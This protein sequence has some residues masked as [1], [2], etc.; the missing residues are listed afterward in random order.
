VAALL[1]TEKRRLTSVVSW[2]LAGSLTPETATDSGVSPPLL[3]PG[4]RRPNLAWTLRKGNPDICLLQDAVPDNLLEF[5]KSDGVLRDFDKRYHFHRSTSGGCVIATLKERFRDPEAC[6]LTFEHGEAAAMASFNSSWDSW[7]LCVSVNIRADT[8]LH[9]DAL[10]DFAQQVAQHRHSFG[11]SAKLLCGVSVSG[12]APHSAEWDEELGGRAAV[13][14]VFNSLGASRD[15]LNTDTDEMARRPTW[16]PLCEGGSMP[17]RA[18]LLLMSSDLDCIK[19]QVAD[20]LTSSKAAA[21]LQQKNQTS[22]ALSSF[23]SSRLPL[24]AVLVDEE[25][26]N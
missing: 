6:P 5:I 25:V 19:A 12:M 9:K 8:A 3:G 15:S 10:E 24:F 20:L 14:E 11:E 16:L 17:V 7:L 21:D 22:W 18:D 13:V 26:G 4:A 1:A 2:N 23:G